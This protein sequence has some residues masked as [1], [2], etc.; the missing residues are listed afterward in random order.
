MPGAKDKKRLVEGDPVGIDGKY[1]VQFFG[2][3]GRDYPQSG[4][5]TVV[6]S[7]PL[8]H[9]RDD[10]KKLTT[11]RGTE[12]RL[13]SDTKSSHLYVIHFN[14]GSPRRSFAYQA[15]LWNGESFCWQGN[16]RPVKRRLFE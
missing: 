3:F 14:G 10:L 5:H 13:K 15:Q 7:R 4:G 8:F 2:R 9:M 1:L 6:E 12:G 16:G 11:I